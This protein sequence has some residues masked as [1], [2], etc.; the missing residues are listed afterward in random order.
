MPGGAKGQLQPGSMCR[1]SPRAVLN[2]GTPSSSTQIKLSG[3]A[4]LLKWLFT[5]LYKNLLTA[6]SSRQQTFG[7]WESFGD[8][9]VYTCSSN[10]L[11]FQSREGTGSY[12]ELRDL[13]HKTTQ[14]NKP[15]V[16]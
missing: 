16:G 10:N 5:H 14:E 6:Y 4:S 15:V 11:C 3:E 13:M 7:L 8:M 2:L 9:Q 1:T 12:P